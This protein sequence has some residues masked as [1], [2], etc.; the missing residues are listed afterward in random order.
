M[1]AH[2]T[3]IYGQSSESTAMISQ[4]M[5]AQIAREL[6]VNE[7]GIYNYPI[8]VDSPSELQHV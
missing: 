4:N 6:G 7:L 2:I 5:T 1:R 8:T 3:N